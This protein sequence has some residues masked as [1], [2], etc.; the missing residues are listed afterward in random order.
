VVTLCIVVAFIAE[1]LVD[2]AAGGLDAPVAYGLS[3]AVGFT[4]GWKAMDW[5]DARVPSKR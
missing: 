5:W 2:W 1:R 3:I 4:V